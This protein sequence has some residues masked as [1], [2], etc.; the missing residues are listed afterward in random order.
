[1]CLI[2]VTTT[3]V[4]DPVPIVYV[5]VLSL[6]M[7]ETCEGAPVTPV[8]SG[9]VLLGFWL[10]LK[11]L[12]VVGNGALGPVLTETDRDGRRLAPG[13]VPRGMELEGTRLALGPVPRGAELDGR[14]LADTLVAEIAGTVLAVDP[15]PIGA[16][17]LE[18]GAGETDG[19]DCGATEVLLC[20]RDPYP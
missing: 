9:T 19:V 4:D 15:V 6:V 5:R 10:A 8:P 7:I 18:I 17:L 3:V 13:P 2:V 12:L 16:E 11:D 20:G 14:R 1:M